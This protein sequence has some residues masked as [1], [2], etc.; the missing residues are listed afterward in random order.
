MKKARKKSRNNIS[1]LELRWS[2][3]LIPLGYFS[4]QLVE[5]VRP[6][7]INKEQKIIIEIFGDYWHCNPQKYEATYFHEKLNRTASEQWKID[8]DRIRYF[9]HLGYAVVVIWESEIKKCKDQN[10]MRLLYASKL[11][12]VQNADN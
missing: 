11:W 1:K 12:E 5:N 8:A 2:K 4:N 3:I 7:W 10:R 9:K 6:D